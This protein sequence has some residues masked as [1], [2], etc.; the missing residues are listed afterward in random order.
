MGKNGQ[1]WTR[2]LR[3]S[4]WLPISIRF[5]TEERFN[6]NHGKTKF[7]HQCEPNKTELRRDSNAHH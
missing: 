4:G 2:K 3:R 1:E 6:F 7:P 5:W